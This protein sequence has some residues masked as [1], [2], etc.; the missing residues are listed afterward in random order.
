M[1]VGLFLQCLVEGRY[2][3]LVKLDFC[4]FVCFVLLL[5]D[6]DLGLVLGD[7]FDEFVLV[8]FESG[9]FLVLVLEDFLHHRQLMFLFLK[10]KYAFGHFFEVASVF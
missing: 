6:A 10:L 8:F 7:L 9:Y 1:F 5:K 4:L 3:L 2:F